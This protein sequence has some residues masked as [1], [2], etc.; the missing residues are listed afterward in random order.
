MTTFTFAVS[1]NAQKKIENAAEKF[2]DAVRKIVSSDLEKPEVVEH[3]NLHFFSN[4]TI[5]NSSKK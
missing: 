4:L 5:E 3:I 2:K 1:K